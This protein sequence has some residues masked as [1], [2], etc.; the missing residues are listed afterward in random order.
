MR[1]EQRRGALA[2]P[3]RRQRIGID[4]DRHAVAQ[5]ALETG[6]G[7]LAAARAHGPRLHAP[8]TDHDLRPRLPYERR[9]G[10]VTDVADHPDTGADRRPRTEHAG[11]GIG[12]GARRHTEDSAAVLVVRTARGREQR[13]DV[14][15]LER[16]DGRR[17]EVRREPDVDQLHHSAYAAPGSTSRPGL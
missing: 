13:R 5:R 14:G 17:R 11:A 10:V 15:Q 7:T 9:R 8:L 6:G 12:V 4:D 1:G 3:V 16:L 2:P